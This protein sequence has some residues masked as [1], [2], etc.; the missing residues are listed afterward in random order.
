MADRAPPKLP[1]SLTDKPEKVIQKVVK[2]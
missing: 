1:A 2:Y